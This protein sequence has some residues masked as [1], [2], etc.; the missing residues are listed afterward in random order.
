M[1]PSFK[2]TTLIAAIGMIV[3]TIY[4]IMLFAIHKF[5]PTPYHYDFWKDIQERLILDILQVSLI[6][7][8]TGLWKYRPSDSASKPFRV[9]TVCL[10]VALAATLLCSPL[11]SYRIVGA[12]YLFPSIYWRVSM[13]VSGIVWLFMLRRQPMEEASPRSYRVTLIIAMVL[14]ALPIVLEMISGLSLALGGNIFCF[15]SYA[16]QSWVRWIAPTLVF[17]HFAFPRIKTNTLKK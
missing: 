17:V 2:T 11:Y 3:Y 14:L 12:A 16:I 7:A 1:K 5:Y 13:L 8:G 4:I 15:K 9:F 10:F 6:T